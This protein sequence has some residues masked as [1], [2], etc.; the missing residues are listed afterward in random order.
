MFTTCHQNHHENQ[1]DDDHDH[2]NENDDNSDTRN[3][4]DADIISDPGYVAAA[5]TVAGRMR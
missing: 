1:D 3:Q 4:S 5:A 2:Q